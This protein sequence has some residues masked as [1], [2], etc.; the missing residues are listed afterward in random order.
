MLSSASSSKKK[1]AQAQAGMGTSTAELQRR[2]DKQDSM[3]K[4][5]VTQNKKKRKSAHVES[6]DEDAN[7]S[8]DND[9]DNEDYTSSESEEEEHRSRRK[10]KRKRTLISRPFGTAGKKGD[11][12][13]GSKGYNLQDHMGLA[14]DNQ[15]YLDIRATGKKCKQD[16]KDMAAIYVAVEKKYP[17]LKDFENSWPIQDMV[18]GILCNR[19]DYKKNRTVQRPKKAEQTRAR[20]LALKE[21]RTEREQVEASNKKEASEE[22]NN[23]SKEV[24]EDQDNCSKEVGED[25][26]NDSNHKEITADNQDGEQSR[27]EYTNGDAD[28]YQPATDD[29]G[30]P[31]PS[32]GDPAPSNGDPAPSNGDPAPSNG[33]P[34]PSN[35]DPAPSN[36]D[37]A[38]SN[39][40]PAP[41]NGDP[42]PSDGEFRGDLPE[43]TSSEDVEEEEVG[44]NDRVFACFVK[45]KAKKVDPRFETQ[46]QGGSKIHHIF[47]PPP[48]SQP[49]QKGP[50]AAP[51]VIAPHQPTPPPS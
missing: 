14:D 46:T 26:D 11:G 34:A 48:N 1:K 20:R 31:A 2:L 16:P 45:K 8:S 12:L 21:A 29:D 6:D 36:G 39:G 49:R 9:D 35:G 5:L 25:Q 33:D 41:S 42:A 13:F 23:H 22:R 37:P 17:E 28:M 50:A 19:T 18:T 15:R 24:S 4:M 7:G 44:D 27:E 51:S 40:D 10:H 3:I 47:I 43:L 32:N 30:D 38:P